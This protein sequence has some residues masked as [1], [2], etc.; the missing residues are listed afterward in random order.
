[1]RVAVLQGN[2]PQEQKWDP[3]MR[4]AIME[5]YID[6]TREAIGAQRAVHPVA[7]VGDAAALRA[8]RAAAAS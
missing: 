8:G 1:M 7:G 4:D 5:R 2:I 3:A 6:M